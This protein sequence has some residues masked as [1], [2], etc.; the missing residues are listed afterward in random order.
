MARSNHLMGRVTGRGKVGLGAKALYNPRS[1]RP[2]PIP[3]GGKDASLRA[4]FRAA[5]KAHGGTGFQ[6]KPNAP[7]GAPQAQK[8]QQGIVGQ[9]AA[10]DA[11][12]N[13][14]VDTAV[15]KGEERLS[16]LS[17]QE[18][19]IKHEFG[20]GDPTSPFSRM[21][22]LK[23][24]F[25]AQRKAAS[26]NLA[27][28]G[29]LYSGTHERALAR[30]RF[31]EEKS[32]SDLRSAFDQAMSQIDQAKSGV[33][34]QTEEEKN[35]AFEDWLARAPEAQDLAPADEVPGP[36]APAAAAPAAAAAAPKAP[37]AQVVSG[38][39]NYGAGVAALI[40]GVADNKGAVG[41][42]PPSMGGTGKPVPLHPKNKGH[43]GRG[44]GKGNRPAARPKN[45]PAARPRGGMTAGVVGR[46]GPARNG[47][48]RGGR[49]RRH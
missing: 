30:S 3:A 13:Q 43:G 34:Y 29:Q 14:Q 16:E 44:H 7:A 9:H 18:R 35:Q 2:K 49:G 19:G 1:N 45:R 26:A 39:G 33:K 4:G 11:L 10:P 31:D 17:G 24:S 48:G 15:H 42:L 23:R 37:A 36:E 27:S 25:L 20:I 41:G 47:G 32:R 22:G 6:A 12:Y 8:P 5:A 21:E 46:G 40:R 38:S 28:E